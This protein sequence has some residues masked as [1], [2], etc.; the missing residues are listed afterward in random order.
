MNF[1]DRLL[2]AGYEFKYRIEF[3]NEHIFPI[4]WVV[5]CFIVLIVIGVFIYVKLNNAVSEKEE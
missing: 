2:I 3:A 1:S 5:L 4:T